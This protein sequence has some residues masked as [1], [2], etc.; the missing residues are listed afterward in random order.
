MKRN[1]KP[2]L[3]TALLSLLFTFPALAAPSTLL[4]EVRET[5]EQE[6]GQ[7]EIR[8][9]LYTYD[10]S[11]RMTAETDLD[12]EGNPKTKQV[13]RYNKDGNMVQS[14]FY[15]IQGK[16]NTLAY[17]RFCEYDEKGNLTKDSSKY[18]DGT[19]SEITYTYEYNA[20]G[21][22]RKKDFSSGWYFLYEN[23]RYG[24]LLRSTVYSTC[25]GSEIISQTVEY[26]DYDEHKNPGVRK[27]YS[28]KTGSLVKESRFHYE[29]GETGDL[30]KKQETETNYESTIPQTTVTE[31]V[32]RYEAAA[33]RG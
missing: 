12:P 31:T 16:E 4:T 10:A 22:I 1:W 9:V 5:Q 25:T 18:P 8:H 28:E 23:D 20:D 7:T 33:S 3:L 11:G 2:A 19:V 24:N 27:T 26:S 6:N 15:S 21:T 29:Y 14:D 17:S 13:Y 32:Y 30:V